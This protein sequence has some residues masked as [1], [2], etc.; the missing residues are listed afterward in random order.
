[1]YERYHT[2]EEE[3][4]A[5]SDAKTA[6]HNTLLQTQSQLHEVAKEKLRNLKLEEDLP[7]AKA[8]PGNS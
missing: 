3:C 1:M 7:K 8:I 6:L 5:L 4:N 2:V